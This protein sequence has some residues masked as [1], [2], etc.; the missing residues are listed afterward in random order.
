MKAEEE[1][2][3]YE[4]CCEDLMEDGFDEISDLTEPEEI[5]C[6]EEER[7]EE[8]QDSAE[9][10]PEPNK[11]ETGSMLDWDSEDYWA[12]GRSERFLLEMAHKDMLCIVGLMEV[13]DSLTLLAETQGRE[14]QYGLSEVSNKLKDKAIAIE[15]RWNTFLNKNYEIR[16]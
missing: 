13:M 8:E 3:E 16:R 1:P 2:E 5:E 7:F 15:N 6:H 9:A 12:Y 14:L 4:F 11:P 10:D